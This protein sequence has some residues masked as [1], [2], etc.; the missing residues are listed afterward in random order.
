MHKVFLIICL[1]VSI[2]IGFTQNSYEKPYDKL[3]RK[4]GLMRHY[5]LVQPSETSSERF[6][7]LN[8]DFFFNNWI[9]NTN[10]VETKFYAIGHGIN[11]MFDIPFSKKS[12]FGIAIGLGYTHYNIRHDGDFRLLPDN[13]T[14][15]LDPDYS[16]LAPHNG[17]DR[18]INRTVFNQVDVPFEFRIRSRK[19]RKKFKFYPGF[20]LGYIF[21]TFEK[22]RIGKYE[23]KTF[24]FPDVNRLQYGP[25]LRFGFNNVFLFGSYN[26][27]YLFSNKNST[28]LNLFSVGVSIG[29]F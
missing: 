1:F 9:G 17:I 23:Y 13:P 8:T 24:N 27:T 22:W 28:E 16:Y 3:D 11:L 12:R 5:T 10:G 6:D 4:P 14:L 26:L 21:D 19:E 29:W 20:K 15:T 18:W 2:T 25:T 7:R